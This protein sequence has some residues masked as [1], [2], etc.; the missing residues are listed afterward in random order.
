MTFPQAVLGGEI[1][2]G[3]LEGTVKMQIPEGTQS[4]T[5]LRLRGKGLPTLGSSA[6]GDEYVRIFVEVPSRLSDRQR[7][8]LEQFAAEGGIEIS[9]KTK[10]FL[11]KLRDLFD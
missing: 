8:L 7:E 3:T 2:V 5:V 11:E 10:S 4:G 1:E 6:R 9:P